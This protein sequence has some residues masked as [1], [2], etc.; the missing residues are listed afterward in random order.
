MVEPTE[1]KVEGE[2]K[3][4]EGTE[5]KVEL[6][7]EQ[8]NALVDRLAE[9]EAGAV[10]QGRRSDE[11]TDLDTLVEEGKRGKATEKIEETEVDFDQLS[12]KELVEY[13]VNLVNDQGL[14]RLQKA[15]VAIETLRVLREIDK[16]EKEHDDFW[17]Y[18]S[19]IRQI[20]MAN[21]TLSIEE[22][23]DLAKVKKGKAKSSKKKEGEI[24]TQ[25]QRLLKLPP[26]HVPGEKPGKVAAGSTRASETK[27]TLKEAAN[28]AWEEVAPK[29][30]REE[31]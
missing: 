14:P 22:A 28:K 7:G 21:P 20:S 9:L 16:G 17:E 4:K 30:V 24:T 27:L 23:Y 19:E 6:S 10:K 5:E 11:V 29:G 2:K 13:V 8:Y 1:K 25:T 18:E 15:E 12:N 26:K 31:E 3:E